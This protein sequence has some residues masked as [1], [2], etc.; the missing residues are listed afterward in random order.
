[1]ISLLAITIYKSLEANKLLHVFKKQKFCSSKQ[2][3]TKKKQPMIPNSA[4]Y[5]NICSKSFR[6]SK[7]HKQD[8]GT[9]EANWNN[10]HA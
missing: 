9:I 10:V 2:T 7:P 4:K 5:L 8:L 1:M 3:T 6:F